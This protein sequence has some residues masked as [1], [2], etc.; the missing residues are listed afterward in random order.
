VGHTRIGKTAAVTEAQDVRV[1]DNPGKSR[2]EVFLDGTLAGFTDYRLRPDNRII[3]VHSEVFP[4]F[5]HHGLASELA[6]E[7][8]DDIRARDLRVMPRC[9]FVKKYI[10]E[11]PDYDD[12]VTDIA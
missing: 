1:A 8:L 2:Y 3:A 11:H 7:M 10:E 4:E 12:L 6:R 5:E 9:P